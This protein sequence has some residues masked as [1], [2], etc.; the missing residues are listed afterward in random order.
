[1]R[2]H[3]GPR[4]EDAD[5]GREPQPDGLQGHGLWARGKPRSGDT[6]WGRDGP[7]VGARGG[8]GQ[9]HEAAWRRPLGQPGCADQGPK[10]K[11]T[12]P[13]LTYL[14]LLMLLMLSLLPL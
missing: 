8:L 6:G 1:M 14:M 11:I 5:L 4:S 3:A 10:S 7:E 2:G 13:K 9:A 12:K